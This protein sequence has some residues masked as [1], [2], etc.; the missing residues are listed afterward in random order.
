MRLL[1]E[2]TVQPGEIDGLGHLNVR[3]YLTRALRGHELLMASLGLDRKTRATA[4]AVL[5]RVDTYCRYHR[6]QRLGARLQSYC[7]WLKTSADSLTA[8]HEIRG[9]GETAATFVI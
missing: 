7:G 2:S 8:Y 3:F 4:G 6:E 5:N 1:D 9:G